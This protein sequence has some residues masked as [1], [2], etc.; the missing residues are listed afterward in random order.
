[1]SWMDRIETPEDRERKQREADRKRETEAAAARLQND[2]YLKEALPLFAELPTGIRLARGTPTVVGTRYSP[3]KL[4]RST[5]MGWP[6]ENQ[7]GDRSSR[8][9]YWVN[10]DGEFRRARYVTDGMLGADEAIDAVTACRA[11]LYG[12]LT[13]LPEEG[14]C[15][16]A[17]YNHVD[18]YYI[19][20]RLDDWLLFRSGATGGLSPITRKDRS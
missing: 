3:L 18:E 8:Y 2:A 14:L 9:R 6:L 10:T 12:V 11:V 17:G 16:R 7:T 15:I 13:R 4:L 20:Y 1:M 5:I 19:F